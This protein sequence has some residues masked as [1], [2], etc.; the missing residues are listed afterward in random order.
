ML[1][2]ETTW[3]VRDGITVAVAHPTDP[4]ACTTTGTAADRDAAR[5]T[6]EEAKYKFQYYVNMEVRQGPAPT[7]QGS[8]TYLSH[9]HI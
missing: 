3:L 8:I 9:C 1:E 5:W 6:W 7:I 2:S 4:G